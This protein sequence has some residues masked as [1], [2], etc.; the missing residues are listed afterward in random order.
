VLCPVAVDDEG[1]LVNC[2]ADVAAGA[3][4]G[5]LDADVLVLLSDVDQLRRDPEDVATSLASVSGGDV[6]AMLASGAVREG[7][8]PKMTAALDALDAGARR[9]LLA[10]GT[11][12]HALRDA[13]AGAI[14][15]TE[16]LA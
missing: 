13:L 15:T 10:N 2:N 16:V 4:A 8:R 5:T 6:R 9:V 7:M 3:L 12:P 14:P 11:R 1:G